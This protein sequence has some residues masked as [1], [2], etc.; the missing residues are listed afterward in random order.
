MPL[1][2]ALL[3]VT[4]S[5][6]L[7]AQTPPA[8]LDWS[9]DDSARIAFAT[10]HGHDSRGGHS[11]VWAPADSLD[12]TW[13]TAFVDSLDAGLARLK[14]LIGGPYSWQRIANRPVLFYLSPGRFVSHASGRD[15]VFISLR[16]VRQRYAP[17]LHE[18]AHEL[19]APPAPF[20]PYE[21]PDSVAEE[22][23]AARFPVWLSEGLADYVA[24]TAASAT[25]FPEGDVFE[26]GGLARAD[27]VCAARLSGSRRRAEILDKVGGNGRLQALFTDERAQV[28][29]A[30]YAC[31]QSFTRYLADRVGV[32]TLVVLFSRVPSGTWLADLEAAAGQSLDALRRAWLVGIG[33]ERTARD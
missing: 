8:R 24:L 30:F 6:E 12:P 19:L 26:I 10:A 16:A 1:A 7:G 14:D 18:A 20:Y 15:A 33:L 27:S 21:Y 28:A 3:L 17:Y 29:P 23:A 25:G 4:L 31:S 5:G 9:A 32:R 13:L 22:V 11:I 2:P